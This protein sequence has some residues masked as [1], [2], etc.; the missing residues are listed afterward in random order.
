MRMMACQA[1]INLINWNKGET[2]ERECVMGRES[3]V[4]RM[5]T[6]KIHFISEERE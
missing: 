4:L 2:I 1:K 5:Q 3:K 6:N